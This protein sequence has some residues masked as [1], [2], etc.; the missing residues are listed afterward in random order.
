MSTAAQVEA[1]RRNAQSSTGPR[2]EEGKA[3]S[4]ANGVRHGLRAE[5]I[6]V[7]D[8]D[9]AEYAEYRQGMLDSLRPEDPL[10]YTLAE[11]VVAQ[12]WRLKRAERA[13]AA[14]LN[15]DMGKA[16]HIAMN[17]LPPQHRQRWDEEPDSIL[18]GIVLG[19]SMSGPSNS[20]ETLRR[21]E[22][23]IERGFYAALHELRAIR[24]ERREDTEREDARTD[25]ERRDAE[26]RRGPDAGAFSR[27][28]QA[29]AH[30]NDDPKAGAQVGVPRPKSESPQTA[31]VPP[32]D[33]SIRMDDVNLPSEPNLGPG[34]GREAALETPPPPDAGQQPE[35]E[36][37]DERLVPAGAGPAH[38]SFERPVLP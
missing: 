19:E 34:H 4:R 23:S 38:P 5:K 9:P 22:R 25:T 24:K 10:E 1:N 12:G 13:E 20:Y 8:E 26:T 32:R 7:M 28:P 31:P 17:E 6:L 14:L 29:S 2:T 11:R 15:R 18:V 33:V 30:A 35:A 21:Y 37:G 3:R 16:H 27:E 36:E